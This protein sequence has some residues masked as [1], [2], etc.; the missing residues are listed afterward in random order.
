MVDINPAQIAFSSFSPG[1]AL[2]A[3]EQMQYRSEMEMQGYHH[4][5]K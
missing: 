1:F 3:A 2:H 4:R 5:G